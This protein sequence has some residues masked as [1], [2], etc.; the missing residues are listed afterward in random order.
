MP[1]LI[2]E[3]S[4]LSTLS[5]ICVILQPNFWHDL[6]LGLWKYS[7]LYGR[8]QDFKAMALKLD[9]YKFLPLLFLTRKL[10]KEEIKELHNSLKILYRPIRVPSTS[11]YTVSDGYIKLSFSLPLPTSTLPHTSHL[12]NLVYP[13]E[14]SP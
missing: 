4:F 10:E 5:Q 12:P 11:F 6:G 9:N 1:S 8:F 14:L 3:D 13:S 7:G 2:L